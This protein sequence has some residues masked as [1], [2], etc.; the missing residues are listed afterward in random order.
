M[1]VTK[2][3]VYNEKGRVGKTPLA[4]EIV[5][6]LG[7]NYATNQNRPRTDIQTV[8]PE[9]EFLQVGPQDRFPQLDDDFPVVFDLAGELVGYE[10]SIASA[11]DQ[12]HK[13]VVPVVNEPDALVG[14]AYAI[15]E[16]KS[17]KSITADFIVVANMLRDHKRDLAEITAALRP[18]LGTQIPIVPVRYSKAF[19]YQLPEKSSVAKLVKRGGLYRWNF[20][21]VCNELD[22]LMT[23]LD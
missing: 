4:L 14:T 17:R 19:E 12:T 16:L 5:L 18:Q 23:F 22:H 13:I 21:N 3:A 7:Y 2:I 11:L 1:P 15:A 8:I 20:R 9:G 10:A 6:R